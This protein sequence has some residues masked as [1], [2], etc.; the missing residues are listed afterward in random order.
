MGRRMDEWINVQVKERR[1]DRLI[2]GAWIDM[3][4]GMCG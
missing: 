1:M 4:G 3:E 2:V